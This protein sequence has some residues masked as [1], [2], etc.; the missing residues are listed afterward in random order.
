MQESKESTKWTY[1]VTAHYT[2]CMEDNSKELQK[3]ILR[4][5]AQL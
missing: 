3:R 4:E 5:E 2:A 1:I